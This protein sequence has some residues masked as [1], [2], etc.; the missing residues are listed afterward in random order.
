MS[1]FTKFWRLDSQEKRLQLRAT[2]LLAVVS[3]E[4]RLTVKGHSGVKNFFSAGVVSR[5]S[6]Q[7]TKPPE[8]IARAVTRSA[9]YVPGAT[10]L[11]QAITLCR[12]LQREGHDSVL[13]VGV[14]PP[15]AGRLQAH[16]WVECGGEIILG[17]TNSADLYATLKSFHGN[18]IHAN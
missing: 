6:R 1:A 10:C 2:A 17:G 12:L 13:Q 8:M 9:R 7:P 4:S 18:K 15:S 5:P 14:K 11:V 16:A 3:L